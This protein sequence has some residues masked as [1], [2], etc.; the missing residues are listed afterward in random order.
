MGRHSPAQGFR[1]SGVANT[2]AVDAEFEAFQAGH[3][4]PALL[5]PDVHHL[6]PHL[7]HATQPPQPLLAR[8]PAVPDWASDFQRLSITNAQGPG[9]Q[10]QRAPAGTASWHQEFLKQQ[11]PAVSAPLNQQQ[12]GFANMSGYGVGRLGGSAFQQP[13]SFGGMSGGMASQLA[14]SEHN[15][16]ASAQQLDAAF[17]QAFA[18][19]DQD[20]AEAASASTPAADVRERTDKRDFRSEQYA[21]LME[22]IGASE[23]GR[24]AVIRLNLRTRSAEEVY[25]HLHEG[26]MD[27]DKL[28]L[29]REYLDDPLGVP[30]ALLPAFRWVVYTRGRGLLHKFREQQPALS[31]LYSAW[32]AIELDDT[33]SAFVFLEAL[34]K[35][36]EKGILLAGPLEAETIVRT[37]KNMLNNTHQEVLRT[38]TERLVQ[39]INERRMSTY[40][41]FSSSSISTGP[42]SLSEEL[43]DVARMQEIMTN[44]IHLQKPDSLPVEPIATPTDMAQA[45]QVNQHQTEAL[46]LQ[47]DDDEMATTAGQLLER[48]A[49]N[50]SEKFQNSQFLELMRKLRDREVKV[51][52]DK[53]V[54]V[55]AQSPRS[56]PAPP[57]SS[58][59]TVHQSQHPPA[60]A[61]SSAIPPIDP[62]ILS[63]AD[64]DFAMPAFPADADV[65]IPPL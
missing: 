15:Q 3:A 33:D 43:Q 21:T 26:S 20:L 1:S 30:E 47:H 12:H 2:G 59:S 17:E 58:S 45:D 56:Q 42:G 49:D 50:T 19:M 27:N 52:G 14:Q 55:S 28:K 24:G 46:P 18:Q 61:S 53:M 65:S 34:E 60:S 35:M 38:R 41:L 6:P 10:Q 32:D 51:E 16:Q 29:A 22:I 5:H 4:G 25:E 48:V 40:S 31:A 8:A 44:F 39:A 63:H 23:A 13:M 64:T 7:V 36:E 9:V 37:L 11:V 54:E 57:S 62:T